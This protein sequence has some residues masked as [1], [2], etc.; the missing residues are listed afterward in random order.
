MIKVCLP[1]SLVSNLILY[2]GVLTLITFIYAVKI[3]FEQNE[4]SEENRSACALVNVCVCGGGV[5][6]VCVKITH[7]Y[8]IFGVK[9]FVTR[10]A[11][12]R[13]DMGNVKKVKLPRLV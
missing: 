12:L 2:S 7:N 4:R 11:C 13:N 1:F 5:R 10:S 3:A 8:M 6:G 9:I